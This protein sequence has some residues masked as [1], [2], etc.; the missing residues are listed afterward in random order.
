MKIKSGCATIFVV[1]R[2]MGY[3]WMAVATPIIYGTFGNELLYNTVCQLSGRF[4]AIACNYVCLV[5]L[6][7]NMVFTVN[8]FGNIK[9]SKSG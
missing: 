9:F 2:S 6:H 3:S 4:R 7:T 1:F 8:G 5:K